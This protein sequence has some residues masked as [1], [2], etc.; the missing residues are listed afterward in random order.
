MEI[1]KELDV[2]FG[3]ADIIQPYVEFINGDQNVYYLTLTPYYE[4]ALIALDEEWTYEFNLEKS[5]GTQYVDNTNI[6]M[7][8]DY[9]L[10]V[11]IK[12]IHIDT[13]GTTHATISCIEL[14]EEED[15]FSIEESE[16]EGYLTITTDIEHGLNDNDE[17]VISGTTN[18]NGTYVVTN[19]TDDT[20][21]IEEEFVEVE[22]EPET[23]VIQ[24][25]SRWTSKPFVYKVGAKV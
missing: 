7:T 23:G 24:T 9:E 18:Y 1:I 4:G 8:D 10:T 3:E 14:G 19:C 21:E 2:E 5:D 11:T 20:F 15:I 25:L 6:E 12:P 16:T 13:I 22:G 17:V